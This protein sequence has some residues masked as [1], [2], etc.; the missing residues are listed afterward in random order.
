MRQEKIDA[1]YELNPFFPNCIP[2]FW[3][4]GIP[5]RIGYESGGFGRLLTKGFAWKDDQSYLAQRYKPFLGLDEE[6][7]LRPFFD[8]NLSSAAHLPL[9]LIA[10]GYAV[11]H[12]GAADPRKQWPSDRWHRLCQEL[13][14][15]GWHLVFT[16]KGRQEREMIEKIRGGCE[17]SLNL[18]DELS[19]KQ[20]VAVIAHA[21]LL[22]S[23]DTAAVHLAGTYEVPS[24]ILFLHTPS[25]ALWMPPHRN[26]RALIEKL[27]EKVYPQDI[28]KTIEMLEFT[29]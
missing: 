23:V 5:S 2:L 1:A 22:I 16:G 10:K 26:C 14:S 19:W 13:A 15:D 7:E 12:V 9:P 8:E 24:I 27:E 25:H 4:A 17:A 28:L 20:F 29:S 11:L 18:A 6:K 21:K 3:K